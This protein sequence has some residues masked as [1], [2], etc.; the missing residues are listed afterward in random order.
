VSPRTL[1]I[2]AL[3]DPVLRRVGR[4]LTAAEIKGKDVQ[5]LIERMRETMRRAPGVGLAAPQI[6]LA[7]KLAVIEDRPE[8]ID[9]MEPEE[10][11]RKE[12]AA[13][14]FHVI[15][16]PRLTVVDSTPMRFF[17]GCL[18]LSGFVAVVGR[19]RAVRVQALDHAGQEVT[20]EAHGWYARILQHEID[21]LNGTVYVDRM[22]PRTFMNADDHA[23]HFAGMPVEVVRAAL[24]AARGLPETLGEAPHQP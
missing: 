10:R 6:G 16:N 8:N 18:S 5:Q 13:V 1:P 23:L 4:E 9:E 24:D 7:V 12:R 22:E 11:D 2:V 19:A 14:P 17:E 21:H 15:V 20:L 3:G